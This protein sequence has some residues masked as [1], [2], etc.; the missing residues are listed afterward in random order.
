MVDLLVA[1]THT[2]NI[3]TKKLMFAVTPTKCGSSCRY[4]GIPHTKRLSD[5]LQA[6]LLF[7]SALLTALSSRLIQ[8]GGCNRTWNP[9]YLRPTLIQPLESRTWQAPTPSRVHN[10]TRS[11]TS[12]CVSDVQRRRVKGCGSMVHIRAGQPRCVP[13]SHCCECRRPRD[14]VVRTVA[15]VSYTHLTLPTTAEV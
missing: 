5:S 15:A 9:T 12:A 6:L 10:M 2:L 4:G 14:A 11:E 13:L 1:S 3:L 8:P 7:R